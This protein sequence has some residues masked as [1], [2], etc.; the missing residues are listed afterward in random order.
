MYN[1]MHK[2]VLCYEKQAPPDSKQQPRENVT[3]SNSVNSQHFVR[4]VTTDF[5]NISNWWAAI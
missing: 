3:F 1:F 2:K 4:E 5:K